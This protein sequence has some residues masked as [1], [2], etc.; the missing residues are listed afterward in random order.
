MLHN[1]G[2]YGPNDGQLNMGTPVNMSQIPGTSIAHNINNFNKI[3][4]PPPQSPG[5]QFLLPDYT[6]YGQL[7]PNMNAQMHQFQGYHHM[8]FHQNFPSQTHPIH[9]NVHWNN[10][11]LPMNLNLQSEH[12]SNIDSFH[13]NLEKRHSETSIIKEHPNSKVMPLNIPHIQTKAFHKQGNAVDT[14]FNDIHSSFYD[15]N[16]DLRVRNHEKIHIDETRRKSLENTVKLIENILINTTTSK[17]EAQT[18]KQDT[19][20]AN[21]TPNRQTMTS[22]STVDIK[23]IYNLEPTML[24]KQTVNHVDKQEY[25]LQPTK[26]TVNA[27]DLNF[28]IEKIHQDRKLIIDNLRNDMNSTKS[29]I[30]ENKHK[31]ISNNLLTRYAE[32][33]HSKSVYKKDNPYTESALQEKPVFTSNK[34]IQRNDK[35]FINHKSSEENI[36]HF[37]DNKTLQE[38]HV[39]HEEIPL[40]KRAINF[41]SNKYIQENNNSF[42]NNNN[43]SREVTDTS[44]NKNLEEKAIHL[45]SSKDLH[46]NYTKNT[47]DKYLHENDNAITTTKSSLDNVNQF[48]KN[49]LQEKP[50]L[51]IDHKTLQ[52][53]NYLTDNM[54]INNTEKN[55]DKAIQDVLFGST[56]D[57]S[58]PIKIR[59][60]G[61]KTEEILNTIQR[62]INETTK[63]SVTTK[64]TSELIELSD[65]VPN[66]DSD[67]LE[68]MEMDV[69]ETDETQAEYNPLDDSHDSEHTEEDI[70]PNI[71]DISRSSQII[72]KVDVKIEN[73]VEDGDVGDPFLKDMHGVLR[74]SAEVNCDIIDMEKSLEEA[75]EAI[76]NGRTTSPYYE[77]PNC[78]LLLKNPKRFLIHAK[79]HTF[80]L[81]QALKEEMRREKEM[82]RHER[83][84]AR[85]IK[86]MNSKEVTEQVNVSGKL[87]PCIECDKVFSTK[88]SMKN[89]KQR[90]HPPRP[91]DCRICHTKITGWNA[92]RAHMAT[93]VIQTSEGYQCTECPKNFKYMHSLVKHKGTH[94]EK[95]HPCPECPK[96][97]GSAILVKMHM[98]SH[99]RVQ[100]GATFRCTYCGKGFF[101]SY[102][103]AVHER[104]HRNER[105]FSC[106]I[107]NTSFGT[108]SSLKRH[109]KVS[110]NA[111]K[112]FECP[113]CHRCFVSAA[114]RDRHLSRNH[115]KPEDFKFPC[116]LCPCKY[117]KL[118]DLQKHEY[119]VHPKQT[120]SKR[121]RK[122][123]TP[124]LKKIQMDE[125]DCSD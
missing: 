29:I 33:Q 5:G 84:E 36:K 81:T 69:P 79:W 116:E 121:K 78:N 19:K 28:N 92:M 50:V 54:K 59:K 24:S 85:V 25:N 27:Q 111:L 11:M 102:N 73:N 125:D 39:D 37:S 86:H 16:L 14:Y 31:D 55:N 8:G 42:T 58:E 80:G 98:K 35:Q 109:L 63:K 6:N 113:Q 100:R 94:M 13:Q 34:Y 119:K 70:K 17:R 52:E 118:K 89:H 49:S 7:P 32:F 95:T 65:I 47:N 114:I 41:T 4:Q 15:S 53:S 117:L 112:P 66:H 20:Q 18:N 68:D 106:D 21:I 48:V 115:G 2:P 46:E 22:S 74:D 23:S 9:P 40:Q 120:L 88:G 71:N 12:S 57:S 1:T 45:S 90:F 76:K 123:R 97:F 83:R 61:S 124:K 62:R 108:K 99:E 64:N 56:L 43:T 96:M 105:P 60:L 44:D 87:F 38:K 72:A 110:H 26:Q 75:K 104:T 122:P 107:C 103:L 3:T 93:H 30:E 67:T 77:C 91:R 10:G 82:R 101:E 51:A